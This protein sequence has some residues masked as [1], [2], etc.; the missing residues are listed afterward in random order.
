MR[1]DSGAPAYAWPVGPGHFAPTSNSGSTALTM[2]TPIQHRL[3][4]KAKPL[5]LIRELAAL[6]FVALGLPQQL[7]ELWEIHSNSPR[8]IAILCG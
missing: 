2:F 4:D 5:V 8:L 7:R 3:G 1:T 6:L